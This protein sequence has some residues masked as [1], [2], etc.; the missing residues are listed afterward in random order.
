MKKVSV[1]VLFFL[2]FVMISQAQVKEDKVILAESAQSSLTVSIDSNKI[3]VQ[4]APANLKL[5]VFSIV[6]VQVVSRKI[7]SANQEFYL[8]LPKGYYI[9]KV[10]DIVRKTALK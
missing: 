9:V 2:A 8:H 1:I 3:S 4:N 5:E 7:N 10:G 6:G